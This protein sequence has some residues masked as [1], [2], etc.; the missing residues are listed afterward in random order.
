MTNRLPKSLR[1]WA[2]RAGFLPQKSYGLGRR[3]RRDGMYLGTSL[4]AEHNQGCRVSRRYIRVLAHLQRMDICDGNFDRW[5]NS[6]GA[7]VPLPRTEAE[8]NTAIR[9]L[10]SKARKRVAEAQA[11]QGDHHEPT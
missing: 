4:R 8:F 10:M 11:D 6:M 3:W 7:S 1:H 2:E 9:T 5:A